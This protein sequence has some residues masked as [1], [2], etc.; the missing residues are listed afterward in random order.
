V[1]KPN[2]V[3][4]GEQL[5]A[6][7]LDAARAETRRCDLMLVAGSSLTVAPAADLPFMARERGADVIV[8]NQGRTPIDEQATLVIRA[9]VSVA[10]PRI[11]AL[12]LEER[13]A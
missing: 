11:A 1:L 8:V 5:P 12:V 13:A 2:V 3:L 7:E 4:V 6:R 9:D 10:L